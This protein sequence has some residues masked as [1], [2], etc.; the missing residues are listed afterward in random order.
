VIV[1]T[2]DF[3]H[4]IHVIALGVVYGDHVSEVVGLPHVFGLSE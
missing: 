4:I 3:T 1:S 2:V